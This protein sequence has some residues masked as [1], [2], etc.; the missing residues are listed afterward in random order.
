MS[1]AA[2]SQTPE[3]KATKKLQDSFAKYVEKVVEY[4]PKALKLLCELIDD[5]GALLQY[6][7]GAAN[8]VTEAYN[9]LYKELKDKKPKDFKKEK[10]ITTGKQKHKKKD[11]M[12]DLEDFKTGTR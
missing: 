11:N 5:E 8:K 12:L 10:Q 3:W 1:R 2:G 6:R 7:L 4:H 9:K